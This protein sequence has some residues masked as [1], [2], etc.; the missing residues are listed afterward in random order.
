MRLPAL[1]PIRLVELLGSTSG[2][3]QRLPVFPGM[4]SGNLNDLPDVVAGMPQGALEGQR[5]AVR[6]STDQYR[7][8]EVFR[9]EALESLQQTGP[10]ALPEVQEFRPAAE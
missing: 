7:F 3:C 1:A 5:H 10:A 8:S 6:F 9:L 2:D 4:D